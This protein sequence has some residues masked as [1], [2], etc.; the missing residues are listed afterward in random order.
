MYDIFPDI[1]SL[2]W[3]C[4]ET[5]LAQLRRYILAEFY[6][7]VTYHLEQQLEAFSPQQ[8]S[9]VYPYSAELKRVIEARVR[10]ICGWFIRP[11]F[12]RDRYSLKMLAMSTLSIVREL[13][14][15][16][17]F[18][19]NVDI[20][21][22]VFL[23]RGSFDV[24]GDALFVLI[25][26]AARHGRKDGR[27]DVSARKLGEN[28]AIVDVISELCPGASYEETFNRIEAATRGESIARSAVEEGF[29]G[30]GKLI[31]L[32]RRVQSPNVKLTLVNRPGRDKILFRL[33]LPTD[34]TARRG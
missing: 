22:G 16:Y 31:G 19:E 30:I 29:S 8:R 10:E 33:E 4:I 21:E 24:F 23:N 28:A 17:A 2:C 18:V 27:I 5:D 3:D 1:F 34:I 15:Q 11:V 32:L 26:N 9:F 20:Q 12:R 6:Q 25:G 14:A 7:R 13:D